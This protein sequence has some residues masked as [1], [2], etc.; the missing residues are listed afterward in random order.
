[1]PLDAIPSYVPENLDTQW[2]S[3]SSFFEERWWWKKLEELSSLKEDWD[4]YGSRPIQPEA[5][6][7][8]A[9]LLSDLVKTDMPEPQIFPVS[10]GGIQLEWE[11]L[12]CE[13]E[14]EVLPDES[15]EYL[16]V[17]E[18]GKMYEGKI[19]QYNNFVEVACLTK[20][21]KSE[22]PSINDL[23]NVYVPTL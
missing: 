21:F 15:I 12:K 19:P 22:K 13:L 7:L 23:L 1:M 5:R 16:I 4:S 8:A 17:D 3:V 20:W 2:S 14:I 10:G 9:K 6:E 18:E 11:N